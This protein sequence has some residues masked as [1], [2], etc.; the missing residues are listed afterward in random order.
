M[1][2]LA[3]VGVLA[4]LAVLLIIVFIFGMGA[5]IAYTAKHPG[6]VFPNYGT[7]LNTPALLVAGRIG[8]VRKLCESS[9]EFDATEPG[10]LSNRAWLAHSVL[11]ILDGNIDAQIND[12]LHR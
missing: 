12:E 2:A 5:G 4:L 1:T 9:M 6:K 10:G 8:H 3:V 11:N 7:T